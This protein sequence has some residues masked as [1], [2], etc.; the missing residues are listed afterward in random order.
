MFTVFIIIYV[1]MFNYC[2]QTEYIIAK[3]R[4]EGGGGGGG[5]G[6]GGGV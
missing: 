6:S 1:V 4:G 3:C 5:G 2:S